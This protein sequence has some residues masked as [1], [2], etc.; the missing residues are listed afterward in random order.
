MPDLES[1]G[2]SQKI[3]NIDFLPAG[4]Q[5]SRFQDDRQYQY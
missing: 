4:R 2:L 3:L 5:V 1:Y